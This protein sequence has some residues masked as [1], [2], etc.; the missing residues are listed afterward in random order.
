MLQ[1]ALEASKKKKLNPREF[2]E[3][4]VQKLFQTESF[5]KFAVELCSSS[6]GI[7]RQEAF[8]EVQEWYLD[9]KVR[10][11]ALGWDPYV[12]RRAD[13]EYVRLVKERA[14]V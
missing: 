8:T 3:V 4:L 7:D 11:R 10:K 9:V 14:Q 12:E 6:P 1:K 5:Y 13:K 2:I